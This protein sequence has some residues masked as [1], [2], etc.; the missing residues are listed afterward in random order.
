LPSASNISRPRAFDCSQVNKD[1]PCDPIARPT[2][3][4]PPHLMP[5]VRDDRDTPLVR[6]E[7]GESVEMICPTPKAKYFCKEDWTGR[8]TLIPRENFLFARTPRER[9]NHGWLAQPSADKNSKAFSRDG[10]RPS[11]R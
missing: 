11:S 9:E 4:R 3:P 2:L 5:N 6:A 10:K 7:T 1:P 8:I